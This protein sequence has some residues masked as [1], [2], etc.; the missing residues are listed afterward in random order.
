MGI[1][2]ESRVYLLPDQRNGVFAFIRSGRVHY[3]RGRRI[4]Y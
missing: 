4:L 2:F 3:N 1:Y